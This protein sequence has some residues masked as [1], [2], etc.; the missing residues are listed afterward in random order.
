MARG[1]I[2]VIV[3]Y[4][5]MMVIVFVTFSIVYLAMGADRAFKPGSYESS[6][7]WLAVSFILGAIAAVIGGVFCRLI[8]QGMT[9][10]WVLAGIVLVLGFAMAIPVLRADPADQPART[11]DVGNMEA[12]QKARMPKVASIVNPLIGALGVAIGGLAIDRRRPVGPNRG[13]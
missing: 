2:G 3:S 4:L 9:A 10:V 6:N 1:I 11:A 5:V 8:A 12:M 7:V 13:V